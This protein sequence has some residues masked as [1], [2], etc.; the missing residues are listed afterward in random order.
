MYDRYAIYAKPEKLREQLAVEVPPSY[1]ANYNAG[2]SQLLPV[3][4]NQDMRG[5]SFFHWGLMTKWSN[6]K[7]ISAKS[8][9]LS[10]AV[11]FQ[12]AGYKRQL[13]TSRCIVPLNGFY[14]W[15]KVSKKQLIPHYFFPTQE[16]IIG[17]AGIWEEFEDQKKSIQ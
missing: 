16:Q 17:V 10:A 2:P 8:I 3:I 15:K 9:N 7:A 5:T 1:K 13:V 6:N 12:R 4:T 14:A 11:A